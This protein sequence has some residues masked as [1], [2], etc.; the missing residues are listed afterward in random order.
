MTVRTGAAD[1]TPWGPW[2]WAWPSR[3]ELD[4][5][6]TVPTELTV[7]SPPSLLQC[8]ELRFADD[9]R[10]YLCPSIVSYQVRQFELLRF[11]PVCPRITCPCFG[12][13][14][15]LL[16][17]GKSKEVPKGAGRGGP[18]GAWRSD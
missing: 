16:P 13:A 9:R 10:I 6:L 17:H 11:S 8:Q 1:R 5:R 12:I 18:P 15:K 4:Q 3:T 14:L 7:S 2:H